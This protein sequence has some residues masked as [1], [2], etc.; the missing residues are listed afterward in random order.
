MRSILLILFCF[1]GQSLLSQCPCDQV[2]LKESVENY[3]LIAL[4]ELIGKYKNTKR[5]NKN[6]DIKRG[7]VNQFE[8][9][10]V[11]KGIDQRRDTITCLTGNGIEDDGYIFN[12]GERYILFHET[13]IDTCSPTTILDYSRYNT[14]LSILNHWNPPPLPPD[15]YS[16]KLYKFE[17]QSGYFDIG[18]NAQIINSNKDSLIE[19][20]NNLLIHEP[21]IDH[22]TLI[23]ITLDENGAVLRE[24]LIDM[25]HKNHKINLPKLIRNFI[26]DK[27]LFK[28]KDQSCLISGSR[29]LYKFD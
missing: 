24:R 11:L 26:E 28:T 25:T 18:L 19:E 29:W 7:I 14:I 12:I 16:S 21:S 9:L 22:K 2:S 4:V 27:L 15:M 3:D 1:L 10:Q 17:S 5:L 6:P 23:M 8:I 20:F 13:Y